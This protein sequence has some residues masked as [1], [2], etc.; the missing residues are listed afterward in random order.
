MKMSCNTTF[1]LVSWPRTV[2]L[3]LNYY[4]GKLYSRA[5]KNTSP[6]NRAGENLSSAVESAVRQLYIALLPIVAA[7][8]VLPQPARNFLVWQPPCCQE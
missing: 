4:G 1:L 6:K 3:T 2:L 8:Y 5:K 7:M